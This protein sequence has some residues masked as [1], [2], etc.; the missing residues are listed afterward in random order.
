[1]CF[2]VPIATAKKCAIMIIVL[3]A[4]RII[5]R[6]RYAVTVTVIKTL[7]DYIIQFKHYLYANHV[8]IPVNRMHCYLS[9]SFVHTHTFIYQTHSAN[10]RT[11]L[12]M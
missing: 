8:P 10:T 4:I 12:S 11:A 7:C 6:R 3:L 1:M 2:H 5:T 9:D